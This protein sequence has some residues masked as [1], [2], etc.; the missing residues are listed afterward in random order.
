MKAGAEEK[1]S[2]KILEI[3]FCATFDL[4]YCFSQCISTFFCQSAFDIFARY[5]TLYLIV[6]KSLFL[7]YIRSGYI[8]WNV[9]SVRDYVYGIYKIRFAKLLCRA[10]VYMGNIR[11]TSFNFA[12]KTKKAAAAA[13]RTHTKTNLF[14]V[15]SNLSQYSTQLRNRKLYIARISFLTQND[16]HISY[17]LEQ[18]LKRTRQIY[19]DHAIC[20]CV[21]S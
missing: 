15:P 20:T 21:P 10:F 6:R 11:N 8:A 5:G 17:L 9:V 2:L 18:K 3:F 12:R 19:D 16:Y 4:G 13:A 7:V 14:L 1:K